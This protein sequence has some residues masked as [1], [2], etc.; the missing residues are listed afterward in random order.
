MPITAR[1]PLGGSKHYNMNNQENAGPAKME[2]VNTQA[3]EKA[4]LKNEAAGRKA[5]ISDLRRD[6]SAHVPIM[7]YE[8]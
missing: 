8:G 6:V 2:E 3:S 4:V 7:P 5:S 1:T